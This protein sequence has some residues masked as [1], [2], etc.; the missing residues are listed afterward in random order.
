MELLC[1][2][3]RVNKMIKTV[4]VIYKIIPFPGFNVV[5]KFNSFDFSS[6]TSEITT[7]SSTKNTLNKQSSFQVSPRITNSTLRTSKKSL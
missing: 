5:R 2:L 6:K 4:E 3:C 7:V 1:A